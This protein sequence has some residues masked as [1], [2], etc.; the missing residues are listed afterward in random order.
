MGIQLSSLFTNLAEYSDLILI[1]MIAFLTAGLVLFL[2]VK[3]TKFFI[4]IFCAI[5]FI[6]SIMANSISYLGSL[7]VLIFAANLVVDIMG[8]RKEVEE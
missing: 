4:Y 8:K 1:G 5:G 2:K 7:A 6:F 3:S